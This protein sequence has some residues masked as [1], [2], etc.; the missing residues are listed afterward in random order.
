MATSNSLWSS[1]CSQGLGRSIKKA[2][3]KVLEDNDGEVFLA[4]GTFQGILWF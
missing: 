2:P 1:G 3:I 4:Q